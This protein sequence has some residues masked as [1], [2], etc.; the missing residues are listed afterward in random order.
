MSSTT[1]S[2]IHHSPQRGYS[3]LLMLLIIA[4]VGIITMIWGERIPTNGGLAWDGRVYGHLAENLDIR[5]LD[6]YY[7]QR[8]LLS[9]LVHFALVV[10]R[11]PI[12]DQHVIVAFYLLDLVAM[13]L[14]CIFYRGIADELGLEN[15]GFWFGFIAIFVNYASLKFIFYNP[16]L[17]EASTVA[18]SLAMLLFYLRRQT[19]LLFL[20]ALLG[21]YTWPTLFDAG[22]FMLAFP[23]EQVEEE[24]KASNTSKWLGA[25]LAASVCVIT[26]LH[27]YV[28]HRPIEAGVPQPM[29]VLIPLSMI[30]SAL[31][32]YT[33][34]TVL[35]KGIDWRASIGSLTVRRVAIATAFV[36]VVKT[37]VI[38]WANHS[39]RA[40]STLG[41]ID[42]I[43]RHT[44][45]KPLVF[46]VSHPMY[47]GPMFL[48]LVFY[49]KPFSQMIR[50]YGLGLV[51]V[52]WMGVYTSLIPES[53][54]SIPSYVM[55]AP[56]LGLLL[57]KL[58]LPSRFLWLTGAL[59]IVSTRV[60]VRMNL[61]AFDDLQFQSF[62]FQNY[63][64]LQGPWMSNQMYLLQ[65]AIVLVAAGLLYACLSPADR[66]PDRVVE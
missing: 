25:V 4:A 49:W 58:A 24:E 11:Q 19:A 31:Y 32:V 5:A 52:I 18:L 56:F 3:F 66:R 46:M 30:L 21:A 60:W 34:S 33:G 12:D 54:Q 1:Q 26:V 38:L 41:T 17:T 50:D 7:F 15:V 2:R 53:R 22:I 45:A 44:V 23:R 20:V 55:A 43:V 42:R 57:D 16:V 51:L 9:F 14:A 28:M 40:V 65:G 27:F 6:T 37:P 35:L 63:Y 39:L 61:P 48:L 47:F 13:L 62:P 29:R 8:P 59:A 10:F 64:M 36:V